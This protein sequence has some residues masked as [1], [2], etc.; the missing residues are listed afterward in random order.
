MK[1]LINKIDPEQM[2]LLAVEKDNPQGHIVVNCDESLAAALLEM[3]QTNSEAKRTLTEIGFLIGLV[4]TTDAN[5][6]RQDVN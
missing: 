4:L 6:K 3:I 1:E 5:D 2:I